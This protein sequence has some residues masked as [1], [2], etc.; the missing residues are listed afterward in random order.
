[1]GADCCADAAIALSK[2]SEAAGDRL[3]RAMR[4]YTIRVLRESNPMERSASPPIAKRVWFD[5]DE[6]FDTQ[7][8]GIPRNGVTATAG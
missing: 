1:M 3:Q 7:R 4:Y 5:A 8:N 6:F 2:K